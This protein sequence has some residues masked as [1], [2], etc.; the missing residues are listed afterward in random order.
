MVQELIEVAIPTLLSSIMAWLQSSSS[1]QVCQFGSLKGS[2]VLTLVCNFQ[3]VSTIAVLM[4]MSLAFS[5]AL[6]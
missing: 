3:V 2:A 1:I 6:G 5:T 4:F